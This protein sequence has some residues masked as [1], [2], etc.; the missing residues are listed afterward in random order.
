[1]ASVSASISQVTKPAMR[2]AKT[3]RRSAVTAALDTRR[4]SVIAGRPFWGVFWSDF[5]PEPPSSPLPQCSAETSIGTASGA[6]LT[7]GEALLKFHH[8]PL[9]LLGAERGE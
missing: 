6:V 3:A 2:A 9:G 4:A 7:A 8:D 5:R 1:M